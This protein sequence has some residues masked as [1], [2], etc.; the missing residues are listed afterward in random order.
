MEH[1]P[2]K[3]HRTST[4]PLYDRGVLPN[5]ILHAILRPAYMHEPEKILCMLS[6]VLSAACSNQS[7]RQRPACMEQAPVKIHRVAAVPLHDH[8]IPPILAVLQL[9]DA[10]RRGT[11]LQ[12]SMHSVSQ[13]RRVAETMPQQSAQSY[14]RL[15]KPH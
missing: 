5:I 11:D 2:A 13:G 9:D 12:E 15:Y 14:C 10:C 4:I 1:A 6:C 8:G 7:T 3:V